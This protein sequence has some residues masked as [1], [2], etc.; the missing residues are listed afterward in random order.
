[1]QLRVSKTI[2]FF[3]EMIKNK[4][5]FSNYVSSELPTLFFGIYR[6]KDIRA[7]E[8]HRGISIVWFAG[9]DSM[10]DSTLKK[11]KE[12]QDIKGITVVA[13]SSWIQSDLER[14][15]IKHET[16]SLF[17]DNIY[18]WKATPLGNSLFWYNAN[19]S[20]YGKKYLPDIKREFPDLN[21]ITN[22]A[23]TTPRDKMPEL[24]S[25]CFAGFR[26]VEHD[27]CS[28]ST[29]EMGLFGRYTIYN[30]DGPHC[31]HYQSI[32]DVIRIIKELQKGYNER[33]VAKRTSDYFKNN[34]KKWCDLVLKLCG[35]DELDVTGIFS[36]SSKRPGS[37]FRIMRSDVVRQMTNWFGTDQ[38]E[39][40]YIINELNRL[41]LKQFITSKH[42][43]FVAGEFK[44][45]GNKGYQEGFKDFHT[46][47]PKY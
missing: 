20:K 3:Q 11:I 22:D 39:R 7:M 30:G 12:L 44:G 2:S 4:F 29:A 26:P 13:E 8:Q 18:K 6:D 25:Q 42:S 17:L 24:Y 21:I 19:S 15:N 34:E 41:G 36:S 33:L 16:I 31:I 1:M 46:Y 45:V 14:F 28:M 40:P 9:S 43:G 23:H 35:I 27:G 38:F 37:I 10:V 5:D 47:D 32:E